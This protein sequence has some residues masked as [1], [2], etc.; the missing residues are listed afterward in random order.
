MSVVVPDGES[1][2]NFVQKL[3]TEIK[4]QLQAAPHR[5]WI[6]GGEAMDL[7]GIKSKT[8]LQKLR[9]EGK[10][11]FSQPQPRI[12]LYDRDSIEQYIEKHAK[13]RLAK[14]IAAAVGEVSQIGAGEKKGTRARDFLNEL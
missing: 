14:N 6:D 1:P 8:A 5:K 9:D 7:L 11:R 2:D 10:I 13:E 3:V 12:I 4:G